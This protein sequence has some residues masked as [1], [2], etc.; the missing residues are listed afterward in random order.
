[1]RRPLITS[2]YPLLQAVS[3][4]KSQKNQKMILQNLAK[5]IKFV[6]C[7]RELAKNTANG[8]LKLSQADKRRL[9]KYSTIVRALIKKKSVNQAGGFI[10]AIL[11]IISSLVG[12]LLIQMIQI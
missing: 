3:K 6:A 8:N 11:P 9:N 4:I 10:Q 5:D 2:Y 7:L 12:S 1:M